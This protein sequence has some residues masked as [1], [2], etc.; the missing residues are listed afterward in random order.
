M[1]GALWKEKTA[2]PSLDG[3]FGSVFSFF[4]AKTIN[5]SVPR[6][7]HTKRLIFFI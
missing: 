1:A 4:L 7:I 6:V 2:N 5:V 3:S